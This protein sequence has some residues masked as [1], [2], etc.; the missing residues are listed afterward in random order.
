MAHVQ[1]PA[2][3]DVYTHPIHHH[4][5]GNV[6]DPICIAGEGCEVR[7]EGNNFVIKV[8]EAKPQALEEFNA[9][10]LLDSMSDLRESHELTSNDIRTQLRENVIQSQTARR[11]IENL[12]SLYAD[13]SARIDLLTANLTLARKVQAYLVLACLTATIISFLAVG[14]AIWI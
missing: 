8:H 1:I 3:E 13:A 9:S 4:A 7:Q 14:L 2:K 6:T 11:Q 10:Y 5:A 12:L